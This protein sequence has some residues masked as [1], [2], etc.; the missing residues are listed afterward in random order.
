MTLPDFN[1]ILQCNRSG[2]CSR[3]CVRMVL[4]KKR[5][6]NIRI[7]IL[8]VLPEYQMSGIGVVLFYE[9][10][11]P[12]VA[13][14]YPHGEASWVLEDNV[15]MNRGAKLMNGTLTKKYRLYQMNFPA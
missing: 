14:G 8:G 12:G 13:N 4:F 3:R 15:M 11:R 5:I 7:I 10:A 9:T 6:S 2:G 1:E